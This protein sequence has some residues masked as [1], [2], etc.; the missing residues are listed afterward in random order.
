MRTTLL[1]IKILIFTITNV[2]YSQN[3]NVTSNY[4]GQYILSDKN[5][6]R[7]GTIMIYSES[8]S[9]LLF[10][11]ELT[12][13][14]PSYNVGNLYGRISIKNAVG[15]Y[16]GNS[17]GTQSQ[18]E[19]IFEFSKNQLT[20]TYSENKNDCGF[21]HSVYANGTYK[22][23]TIISTNYFQDLEGRKVYFKE[24]SPEEYYKN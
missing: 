18:C 9:T 2:T 13:G 10:Y 17:L 12:S 21:G 23:K 6:N 24:T 7:N 5:K 8:D 3:S 22:L 19:L 1:I 15:E 14:K 4:S 20:I 11:L 16:L